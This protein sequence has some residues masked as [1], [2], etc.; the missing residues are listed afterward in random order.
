MTKILRNRMTGITIW[1][2]FTRKAEFKERERYFCVVSGRE[3]FR[4]VSPVYKQN[5]YSGVLD[6]LKPEETPVNL[7]GNYDYGKFP[8]LRQAKVQILQ[9]SAGSCLFVP[10]FWWVQSSTLSD[11]SVLLN[12]EYEAHSELANLFFRAIDHGIL[13]D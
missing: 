1:S 2:E 3:E 9:L 7:F 8:L 12:F 5:I 11:Y 13:E 4:L 6:E 10:A